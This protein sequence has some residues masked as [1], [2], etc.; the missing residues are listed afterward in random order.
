MPDNGSGTKEE[1]CFD[2]RH[3]TKL[4]VLPVVPSGEAVVCLLWHLR[5]PSNWVM[6]SCVAVARRAGDERVGRG[7]LGKSAV[8]Q[9]PSR[10]CSLRFDHTASSSIPPHVCTVR[11]Q[12]D[13][14]ESTVFFFLSLNIEFS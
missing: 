12:S 4:G 6:A 13:S 2:H 10:P 7:R 8:A 1:I 14:P 3:K 11:A 9:A 5:R